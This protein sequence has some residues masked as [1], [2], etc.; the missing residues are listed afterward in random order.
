MRIAVSGLAATAMLALTSAATAQNISNPNAL[1]YYQQIQSYQPN[2]IQPAAT[3]TYQTPATAQPTLGSALYRGTSTYAPQAPTAYTPPANPY[4][5]Q[6]VGT[7]YEPAAPS[8]APQQAGPTYATAP[9]AQSVPSYSTTTPSYGSPYTPTQQ[10]TFAAPEPT[11]VAP[12]Y[13]TATT[14]YQQPSYGAITSQPLPAAP[15]AASAYTP[16]V[17]TS[18]APT[19]T[20][21]APEI[22][23]TDGWTYNLARFYPAVQACLRKNTAKNPVIA[24]IQERDNKTMMLIGEGGSSNYSTCTT[25]LTGTVVKAN[26]EIRNIPPAFFAPLGST[27]TVNPERPFQPIVDTNQKVIGW[28]VRTQPSQ[29]VNQFG[30][31]AGFDGQFIP[32]MMVNTSVGKS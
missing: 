32:P 26:S 6:Q 24:N 18:T 25:G 23:D 4:A 17:P 8:Y 16:S 19:A 5:P 2:V 12:T 29:G 21:T 14:T 20:T 30:Q 9:A 13:G 11:Y 15:L 10:T 28:L 31:S 27:F 1:S 3:S 22:A 7:T